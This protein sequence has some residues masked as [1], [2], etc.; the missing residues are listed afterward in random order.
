MA[1]EA[2]RAILVRTICIGVLLGVGELLLDLYPVRLVAQGVGSNLTI[3]LDGGIK[4]FQLPWP[5]ASFRIPPAQPLEREYQI[6]GSDSVERRTF[7]P[8]HFAALSTTPYYRLQAWLRDEGSYSRWQNLVVRDDAAGIV[9]LQ[10]DRPPVQQIAL[11][12]RFTLSIDLHRIEAPRSVQFSGEDGTAVTITINRNDKLVRLTESGPDQP[13]REL[14]R[15]YF[16]HD[17][18]P[19]AAQILALV[20]R[21]GAIALAVSLLLVP[22][23]WLLPGRPVR[24]P[25][26]YLARF[27][28]PLALAVVLAGTLAT[29]VVLFDRA[30][31]LADSVSYYFQGKIFASG[32]WAAPAPP[33]PAAF[34]TPFMS[35]HQGKWFSP[36]P[37]GTSLVLALGFRLGLPWL[38]EPL[39]ALA[40]AWL[41]YQVGR[42]QFGTT[43]GLLALVLLASS[44]FLHLISGTFMSHVPGMLCGVGFIYA[45][46]RYCQRPARKWAL[47]GAVSLGAAVHVREITAIIYALGVGLFLLAQAW[48]SSKRFIWR[49]ALANRWGDGAVFAGG[50]AVFAL[51]Y[52]LYNLALTGDPFLL[53]RH[54]RWAPDRIGFGEGVGFYGQHTLAS[55]LVNADQMLTAL[56]ISLLGWPFYLTLALIAIPFLL[57]RA[58]SWDWLH[59]LIFT[60]FVLTYI[61]YYYN[62]IIL[63]G[64]RYY[65][66]ALPSLILLSAR[67]F[68]VLSRDTARLLRSLRRDKTWAIDRCRA[69][70]AAFVFG[71]A[72]VACNLLYFAPRQF[73]LYQRFPNYPRPNTVLGDFVG[74]DMTGRVSALSDAVVTIDD[75]L[76]FGVYLAALN[77]PCLDCS[78]VFAYLPDQQSEAELRA[79]FPDRTWFRVVD[80]DRV[81]TLEPY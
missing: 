11:P 30:P 22:L 41:I 27:V 7:D 9:A 64:P 40:A 10:A 28:P 51:G 68:I 4:R 56:T 14:A 75:P 34:P 19:P 3:D 80:R 32:S 37:P 70:N 29:T 38:V 74:R 58:T 45:A 77:H 63:G 54:V 72:L 79:A 42:A 36:Y 53:P 62:G 44:P 57:G 31:H 81:L 17:W 39:L 73:V 25:D 46:T 69:R 78:T 15:W 2:W 21:A 55:G 24:G 65:F 67:G 12:E 1:A 61:A 16:P 52:F 71:V 5:I 33:V 50:L 13:E 8:E 26:R 76:V 20:A 23:A 43:T 48:R 60:G 47:L 18:R 59:G 6:D 49:R 66:D 35:I